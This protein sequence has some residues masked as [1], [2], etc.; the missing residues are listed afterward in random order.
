[1]PKT[2]P[3]NLNFSDGGGGGALSE[4]LNN[5]PKPTRRRDPPQIPCRITALFKLCVQ[6]SATAAAAF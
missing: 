5:I 2:L 3:G 4:N 6:S 1:V